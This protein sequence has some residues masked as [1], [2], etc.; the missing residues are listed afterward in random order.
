MVGQNL[1]KVRRFHGSSQEQMA[2]SL[3][4]SLSQYKKYEQGKDLPKIHTAARWSLVTG[5]N[6]YCLLV[7]S[8]YCQLLPKINLFGQVMP[9]NL[10]LS[11]LNER[12]FRHF[13]GLLAASAPTEPNWQEPE[14][15]TDLCWQRL[16]RQ[17]DGEYYVQIAKNLRLWRQHQGLSQEQVAHTL[18][19]TTA[20]YACY[21]REHDVTRFSLLMAPRFALAFNTNTWF[22]GQGTHYAWYRA[23]QEVRYAMFAKLWPQLP[24]TSQDHAYQLAANIRQWMHNQPSL[25]FGPQEPLDVDTERPFA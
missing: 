9:F 1:A 7:G 2:R 8:H 18:G 3:N 14:L 6:F 23:R 25:A 5:S 16:M 12:P 15:P 19:I 21:E 10:L 22:L 13:I 24:K 17:L 11:R 20:T 4:V